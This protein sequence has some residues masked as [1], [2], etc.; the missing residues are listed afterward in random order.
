MLNATPIAAHLIRELVE[1]GPA[2]APRGP[3]AQ[4]LPRL[5]LAAARRLRVAAARLEPRPE[6]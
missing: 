2:R 1:R 3:R 6:C 5:R 4:R